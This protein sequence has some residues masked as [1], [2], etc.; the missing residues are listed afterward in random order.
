MEVYISHEGQNL[1]PYSIEELKEMLDSGNV[2]ADLPAWHEGMGDWATVGAVVEELAPA[3]GD[4]TTE[5]DGLPLIA[6]TPGED[7]SRTRSSKLRP[8]GETL[9]EPGTADPSPPRDDPSEDPALSSLRTP[10]HTEGASFDQAEPI[11]ST[12]K[13]KAKKKKKNS[14]GIPLSWLKLLGVVCVAGIFFS[15]VLP[16]IKAGPSEPLQRATLGELFLTSD[17]VK[18]QFGIDTPKFLRFLLIVSC[19]GLLVSGLFASFYSLKLALKPIHMLSI[20][21][22]AIIVF[23]LSLVGFLYFFYDIRLESLADASAEGRAIFVPVKMDMGFY[24]ALGIL[25]AMLGIFALPDKPTLSQLPAKMFGPLL[26]LGGAGYLF[27]LADQ[28][29]QE[30]DITYED[31]LPRS[32]EFIEKVQEVFKNRNSGSNA[33]S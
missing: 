16:W 1:G 11:D 27:Y 14:P 30:T 29:R 32:E 26:L 6:A 20:G 33:E 24:F 19:G 9:P 22:C 12:P 4:A 25:V 13:K 28:M 15:M 5:N 17:Q 10:D 7:P 21:A 31:I 18:G 8:P 3:P 23:A 2:A